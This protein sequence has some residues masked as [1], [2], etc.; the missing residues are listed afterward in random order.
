MKIVTF[1]LRFDTPD[2]GPFAFSYRKEEVIRRLREE[3]PDVVGYAHLHMPIIF[4]VE[5]KTIFN[6]GSV[7]ASYNKGEATYTI[8][9][10]EFNSLK[11]K[12]KES[13]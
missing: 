10:G 4:K 12:K 13:C 9:E 7:G 2:D 1:N 3:M 6:T 11:I 5:D 8:L